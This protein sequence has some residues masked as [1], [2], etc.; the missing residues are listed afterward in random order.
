[1]APTTSDG[2]GAANALIYVCIR[3]KERF[4]DFRPETQSVAINFADRT[5]EISFKVS[6]PGGWRKRQ[7]RIAVPAHEGFAITKMFDTAFNQHRHEWRRAGTE[8]VLD[9]KKLPS[10]ETY[11]V[12]MEGQVDRDALR[13]LVYIKP[14]TNRVSGEN[15]DRY[16]LESWI[17]NPGMLE[18]I[19]TD[20]EIDD[21][22]FAVGVIIGKMFIPTVPP[23]IS[24]Q[25]KT[26]GSAFRAASDMDELGWINAMRSYGAQSRTHPD[27]DEASFT[28][29]SIG[30][31]QGGSGRVRHRGSSLPARH[32]AAS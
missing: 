18:S 3:L 22:N 17:R 12:T 32:G 16:W 25:A 19:Y 6:I 23:E 21:V 26:V 30:S 9:A 11:L 24:A 2:I 10:S 13:Q 20:L 15:Y 31:R 14:A 1:M 8:Y 5:C 7:R 27:Y 29:P 4:S 28:R